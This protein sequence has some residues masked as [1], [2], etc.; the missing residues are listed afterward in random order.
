LN[1]NVILV[2]ACLECVELCELCGLKILGII[3]NNQTESFFGVPVIGNDGDVKQIAKRYAAA[4]GLVL[5]QDQP[6]IRKKLYE[7]YSKH[8][9]SFSSVISPKATISKT[10]KIGTGTIIQSGVNVASNTV[11]SSFV[12]VN[13]NANIM[14]DCQIGDYVTLAPNSI[15]LGRVIIKDRVYVGANSTI[16]PEKKIANDVIVGAGAVVTKDITAHETIVGVPA[17][18]IKK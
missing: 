10:A 3:D 9:F 8:G 5:T 1:I 4:A 12:N 14:H 7:Y 2:G 13:T 11:I 16:L 15:V 18:P 17:R 6:N